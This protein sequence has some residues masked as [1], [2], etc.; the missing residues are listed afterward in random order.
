MKLEY[1]HDLSELEEHEDM[2]LEGATPTEKG[3]A[4]E[5]LTEINVANLS[6]YEKIRN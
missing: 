3:K 6:K 5:L 1:L 2:D 4:I